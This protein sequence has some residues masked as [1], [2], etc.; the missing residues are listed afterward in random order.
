M[1]KYTK[2]AGRRARIQKLIDEQ[3][4]GIIAEFARRI[5][6]DVSYAGR[7]LYPIGKP[8]KRGITEQTVEVI[9]AAFNLSHG[10]LDGIEPPD[11]YMAEIIRLW[12]NLAE[13]KR[14]ALAGMARELSAPSDNPPEEKKCLSEAPPLKRRTTGERRTKVRGT[15]DRRQGSINHFPPPPGQ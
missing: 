15:P 4:G 13:Y 11:A 9:E 10:W 6:K 5:K 2:D 1:D 12:P 8:G 3:C 7:M 14:R